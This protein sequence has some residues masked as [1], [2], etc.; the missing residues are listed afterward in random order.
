[1]VELLDEGA[2]KEYREGVRAQRS[3]LQRLGVLLLRLA[4]CVSV[5]TIGL[6]SF[7]FAKH[8]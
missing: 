7:L 2:N 5:L 8:Q 6:S 3:V 4:V 1:M